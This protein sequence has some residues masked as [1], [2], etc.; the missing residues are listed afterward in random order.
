MDYQIKPIDVDGTEADGVYVNDHGAWLGIVDWQAVDGGD[1][2]QIVLPL[3]DEDLNCVLAP[4]NWREL[5][6]KELGDNDRRK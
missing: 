3:M 1:D 2:K 5:V 6:V 4:E